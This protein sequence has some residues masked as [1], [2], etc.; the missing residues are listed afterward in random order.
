MILRQPP[1]IVADPE[2]T[3]INLKANNGGT[4]TVGILIVSD[5]VNANKGARLGLK[6]LE[7]I[8]QPKILKVANKLKEDSSHKREM[9]YEIANSVAT[10][11]VNAASSAQ[12]KIGSGDNISAATIFCQ[13]SF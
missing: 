5:G 10:E 1:F 8:V 3:K 2:I 4:E 13:S 7:K 12:E 6:A 9:L 11:I